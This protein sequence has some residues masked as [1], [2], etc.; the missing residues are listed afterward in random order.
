VPVRAGLASDVPAL[1]VISGR[2]ADGSTRLGIS[3]AATRSTDGRRRQPR[4]QAVL[5]SDQ[6]VKIDPTFRST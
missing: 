1:P 5:R 2:M 6:V 3:S 4:Q